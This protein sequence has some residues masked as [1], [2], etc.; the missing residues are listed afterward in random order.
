MNKPAFISVVIPTFK[1]LK[2]L[3]SAVYSVKGQSFKDWELV[4]SDDEFS[5]GET[6][7]WL[8]EEAKH[9]TR[10]KPVK[11]LSQKGQVG[12]TNY[13]ISQ[14]NGHYIKILHD[15]DLLLPTCL[16]EFKKAVDHYPDIEVVTCRARIVKNGFTTQEYRGKKNNKYKHL[17]PE[18]AGKAMYLARDTGG[19]IPSSLLIKRSVF[20]K[21]GLMPQHDQISYCIDSVWNMHLIQFGNRLIINE[22]LA[23]HH[24]E[25]NTKSITSE[26]TEAEYMEELF[27]LRQYQHSIMTKLNVKVPSLEIVNQQSYIFFALR[28]FQRL[29][30]GYGF[31][32]LTTCW[33]PYSWILFIRYCLD[34]LFTT[35][36]FRS[37]LKKKH[38]VE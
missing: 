22:V 30:I 28:G 33:H 1:R 5:S 31:K 23:E 12:N 25:D 9:D 8:Q 2:R 37:T 34:T 32:L 21:G 36:R 26:T 35:R 14:A 17:T 18:Q 19:G 11:N 29:E 3:I 6:W 4:I 38:R 20:S 15:D 7:Y 10:I 13:G 16:E 24:S 27:H